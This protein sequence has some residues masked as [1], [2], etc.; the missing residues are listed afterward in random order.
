MRMLA[1]PARFSPSL[2]EDQQECVGGEVLQCRKGF[3]SP[4][5]RFAWVVLLSL[6]P[7]S[8]LFNAGKSQALSYLGG[9]LVILMGIT[10]VSRQVKL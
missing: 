2:S 1:K 7:T 3:V 6:S 9:S 10:K 4:C 8:T 5:V